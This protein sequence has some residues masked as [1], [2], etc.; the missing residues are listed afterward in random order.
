MLS[1][2]AEKRDI[3]GK[4]VAGL[5]AQ[6]KLPVVVYGPKEKNGSYSVDAKTFLA[7]WRKA[8]AS[9]IISFSVGG[10]EMD[11]LIQEVSLDPITDLPVHADRTP[12]A[13]SDAA[14]IL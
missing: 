9:S 7:L 13:G 10:D 5:R 1:L 6:G 8:G 4:K 12:P 11:V 14:G 3:F 2:Q